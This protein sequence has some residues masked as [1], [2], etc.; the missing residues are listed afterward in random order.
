V[1]LAVLFSLKGVY[2]GLWPGLV[3]TT[4]TEKARW[5]AWTRGTQQIFVSGWI[6]K[7]PCFGSG[8]RDPVAVYIQSRYLL[9]R[10]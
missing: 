10:C 3:F 8:T 5:Y 7:M 4:T 2:L 6:C 1:L 9:F